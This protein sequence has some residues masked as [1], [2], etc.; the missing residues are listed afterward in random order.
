MQ[1]K[2]SLDIRIGASTE[3]NTPDVFLDP[4]SKIHVEVSADTGS[5]LHNLAVN[6]GF[7]SVTLDS[8]A[9][10]SFSG[11]LDV[12]ATDPNGNGRITPTE[13]TS[14]GASSLLVLSDN[15]VSSLSGTLTASVGGIDLTGGGSLVSG[16]LT[17][18]LTGSIFGGQGAAPNIEVSF[19]STAGDLL[20]KFKNI[21][22]SDVLGMLNQILG[23]LSSMASSSAVNL[24]IPFTSLTVGQVIDFATSFKHTVLD[25]LFKSGDAFKPDANGDGNFNADDINFSSVQDFLNRIA[26]GIGFSPG[27]L[28][29][30]F[31]SSTGELTFPFSFET[32][33]GFGTPVVVSFATGA[34]IATLFDGNA[35][36]STTVNGAQ[37]LGTG[38][39]TVNSTTGFVNGQSSFRI[40]STVCNYNGTDATHLKS[41]SS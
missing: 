16:T 3:L 31:D 33:L 17:F 1:A 32:N 37:T 15:P 7:L 22:P 21:G 39:L 28:K 6:L 24:P 10:I 11:G 40:G 20:N 30:D 36:A 26:V 25:P 23:L 14:T 34:T 12:T 35:G 29:A 18:S 2:Y 13:I 38:N 19:S 5:S 9:H 8:S 27:T 41:V 4:G